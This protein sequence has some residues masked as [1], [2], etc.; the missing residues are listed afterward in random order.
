MSD[1]VPF[2]DLMAARRE[3]G[4]ALDDAILGVVNGGRYLLGPALE[5]FEHEFAAYTGATHAI[6]V[7]NGLDALSLAL[8]ALEVGPGDEV[9]VPAHTFVASWLAVTAVGATPVAVDVD[10]GTC[11]LQ[12]DAAA[13]AV[14]PRTTAIMPVHLYGQP[15]DLEAFG[16]LARE[17]GLRL[18]YDAAQAHGA[19]VRGAPIGNAGDASGWSFY[20]GKN[21]GALGDGGG[22]TTPR[23]DV[24]ERLHALRNYGSR[25]KYVHER[26]GINSRLD[27]LQAAVLSTKLRVL[28]EWNA[29]RGRIAS[30]YLEALAGASLVLPVVPAWAEP[31]WHLFVV[32]VEDR[33]RVAAA[34]DAEGVETIVHYPTPPHL[35][36]VYAAAG[37][38]EGSFPVAERLARQVLS[39]PI[40]P[41]LGE[42]QAERVVRAV[43]AVLG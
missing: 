28:D 6:G 27:D 35:Q 17:R 4:R 10:P 33:D 22:V 8:R 38:G 37:W 19:R 25:R 29:R 30:Y 5:G 31:V 40:G 21:L 42:A 12:A 14:T 34:L 9:I 15:V 2:L 16:A 7:A 39:L 24:A 20:P 3:L 1:R 41:H 36:G 43:R 13:R 26:F 32:Q 11:N 18:V 23:D